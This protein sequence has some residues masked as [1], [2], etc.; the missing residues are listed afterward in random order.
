MGRD[1]WGFLGL[2][3]NESH[4]GPVIL[5]C[6]ADVWHNDLLENQSNTQLALNSFTYADRTSLG[7]IDGNFN[8]LSSFL[9]QGDSEEFI[10]SVRNEGD[11]VLEIGLEVSVDVNWLSFEPAYA[12]LEAGE[13]LDISIIV[14]TDGLVADMNEAAE[15]TIYHSDPTNN[16]FQTQISIT[17]LDEDPTHFEMVAPTG[18]DH[19]LLIQELTIDGASTRAG[20]EVGVF[21]PNDVCAG[22]FRYLGEAFGMPA[23]GDDP[24][25]NE[26]E[27]FLPDERISYK[28]FIPWENREIGAVP[29]YLQGG[30][31][32]RPDGLS[33]LELCGNPYSNQTISLRNRWNL[34]S[35]NV[36]PNN[37]NFESILTP[38]LE[39]QLILMVKDGRGH[40]WNIRNGF[41]N[42]GDWNLSQ[43]YEICVAHPT[44]LEIE[45]IEVQA[46]HPILVDP[47]WSIIPYLLTQPANITFAL[48]SI[49]ENL[50]FAKQTNGAFYSP[51]W[52]W[53]GIGNMM[54][55]NGYKISMTGEGTLIY[56]D[57]DE[58]NMLANTS[59]FVPSPSGFDM[60][61]LLTDLQPNDR[62]RLTNRTNI[63]V[64]AGIVGDD[65]RLGMSVW[66][67]DPSTE[68]L[69]G[70]TV[71]EEFSIQVHESG[72][73]KNHNVEW[74]Q[75]NNSYSPDG[76]SVGEA[77][78][79]S[80]LPK[81]FDIS[82][83]PNPFNDRFTINI[84]GGSGQTS[85][86]IYDI[87]GR[88]LETWAGK[89]TDAE[90]SLNFIG[91]EIPAGVIFINVQVQN[92]EKII[93]AVYL[94]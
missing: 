73:W 52:D 61:L 94:P 72:E 48:S 78:A 22:A 38:L 10:L 51:E 47:G 35:L 93:K 40:F 76:L 91:H 44:E 2:A 31:L 49:E 26:I 23:R 3:V 83:F 66:G 30:G 33:I 14:N 24:I 43:G 12:S 8:N 55:G 11:G 25:T 74:L 9:M 67:D 5:I 92:Q 50:R 79:E 90:T 54:P 32:F 53:N 18:Y 4:N 81:A 19:S 86:R 64:G 34:V 65:G 57:A 45:G 42:L 87:S 46:D 17:I 84:S 70:L 6:D 59:S 37:L 77:L 89:I 29:T 75:G 62:V 36:R 88:I 28:L 82:C 16:F 41:N 69:E 68:Q 39:E 15:I 20:I 13:D 1:D 7:R 27:G 21:T 56:S 60:S 80:I 85:V 58:V 63:E 71:N